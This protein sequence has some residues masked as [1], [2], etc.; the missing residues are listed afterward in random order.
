G[1]SAEYDSNPFGLEEIR[2][3]ASS[4]SAGKKVHELNQVLEYDCHL[5]SGPSF[6]TDFLHSGFGRCAFPLQ[7]I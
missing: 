4:I 1:D 2:V 3:R 5:S 6:S 7:L